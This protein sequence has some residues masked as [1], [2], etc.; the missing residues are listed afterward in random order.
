MEKPSVLAGAEKSPAS[1]GA[2]AHCGKTATSRSITV[3]KLGFPKT[4]WRIAAPAGTNLQWWCFEMA[5]GLREVS[6]KPE[7]N[8]PCSTPAT[9]RRPPPLVQIEKIG[10]DLSV[11]RLWAAGIDSM[12]GGETD[13]CVLSTMLGAVDWGFRVVLVTD[14]LCSSADETHDAMMDLYC[15]RFGEQVETAPTEVVLRLWSP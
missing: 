7:G 4:E 1:S 3:E 8:L 15:N 2:S 12:K 5:G 6:G 9:D 11:P 14:A 10:I 13:V